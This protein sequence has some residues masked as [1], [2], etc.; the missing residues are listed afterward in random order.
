M[1]SGLWIMELSTA[2]YFLSL[3][4]P[5][6]SKTFAFLVRINYELWCVLMQAG[7]DAFD[8]DALFPSLELKVM[9][10]FNSD[11]FHENPSGG[12]WVFPYGQ[13][14]IWTDGNT[15]MKS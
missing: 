6:P 2:Q 3:L 13:T 11:I 8:S 9:Y 12:R 7:T 10:S 14:N 4:L 5:P 15:D 1:W